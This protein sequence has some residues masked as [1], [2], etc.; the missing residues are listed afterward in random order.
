MPIRAPCPV[1]LLLAAVLIY[2]ISISAL[3]G[4]PRTRPI[5]LPYPSLGCA[6]RPGP[7]CRPSQVQSRPSQVQSR[8]SQPRSK[9]AYC[10]PNP[11]V[12][13]SC[14]HRQCCPKRVVADVSPAHPTS[15]DP[16]PRDPRVSNHHLRG[17]SFVIYEDE[18][19]LPCPVPLPCF[20]LRTH[21]VTHHSGNQVPRPGCFGVGSQ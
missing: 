7:G 19:P 13:S 5:T 15:N 8:P 4:D 10:P 18:G 1:R 6:C 12:P 9:Q 17:L 14:F 21:I 11:A 3:D 16:C 20:A 2:A